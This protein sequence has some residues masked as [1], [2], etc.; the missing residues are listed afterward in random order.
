MDFLYLTVCT[1]H[2]FVRILLDERDRNPSQISF[3]KNVMF[4]RWMIVVIEQ[5]CR[6]TWCHGTVH[7]RKVS[8]WVPL[9][10][11]VWRGFRKLSFPLCPLDI[12]CLASHQFCFKLQKCKFPSIC[13]RDLWE[14]GVHCG[15]GPSWQWTVGVG[16]GAVK[17]KVLKVEWSAWA[18]VWR[19][20]NTGK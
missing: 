11:G 8:L 6:C 15:M 20:G 19:W 16:L 14:A 3:S 10:W 1:M 5:Q 4:R 17:S 13:E 7:F 12:K 9:C 2:F 18:M